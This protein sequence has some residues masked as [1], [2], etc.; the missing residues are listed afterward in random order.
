MAC[1]N[2]SKRGFSALLF[3]VHGCCIFGHEVHH[4]WVRGNV[5]SF[6]IWRHHHHTY[7]DP[8]QSNYVSLTSFHSDTW[9]KMLS[10]HK[11]AITRSTRENIKYPIGTKIPATKFL[12]KQWSFLKISRKAEACCQAKALYSRLHY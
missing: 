10:D 12:S 4:H 1:C 7:G 6:Q 5:L 2:L 11:T 8:L 3:S 9:K